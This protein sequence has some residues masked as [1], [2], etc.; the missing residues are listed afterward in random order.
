MHYNL[1]LSCLDRKQ[2]KKEFICKKHWWV[3]YVTWEVYCKLAYIQ[4]LVGACMHVHGTRYKSK[5][6]KSLFSYLF[7]WKRLDDMFKNTD[8]SCSSFNYIVTFP[9][10]QTH[11]S[12]NIE[13][14]LMLG[15]MAK[16]D[17]R[18][19][20]KDSLIE[21]QSSPDSTPVTWLHETI[22]FV[23]LRPPVH[24]SINQKWKIF[25]T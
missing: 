18:V 8:Y 23:S 12:T 15:L 10:T 19:N 11:W 24:D 13:L 25:S 7:S 4:L 17:C 21:V 3:E 16:K 6:D 22:A 20:L 1:F 14:Q 5:V 9:S 2:L